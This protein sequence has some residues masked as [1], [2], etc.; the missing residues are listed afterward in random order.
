MKAKRILQLQ[1]NAIGKDKVKAAWRPNSDQ[2]AVAAEKDG[3][4]LLNLYSR[5]SMPKPIEVHNLG[6][7]R[8]TWIDWDCQGT[9]LAIMQEGVGIY[10]WDPPADPNGSTS[11][12]LRLA[13]SITNATSFCMWSKKHQ[14][15]AI[16]TTTGK[17]STG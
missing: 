7:G 4:L 8:P 11:Q 12:P 16:G 15:L 5:R 6:P 9:S 2:I 14:Q 13:P 17:V 10:L 1:P 3:H